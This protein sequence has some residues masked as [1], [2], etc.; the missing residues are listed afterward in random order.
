MNNNLQKLG[1]AN[2]YEFIEAIDSAINILQKERSK[3]RHI[4]G[5]KINSGLIELD[6]PKNLVIVGDLH[7]DLL[8]LQR[9]LEEIDYEH[10]LS[11]QNNKM[12]F[13]GDYV[14]RGTHSISVLY[15]ICYLK[16]KYPDSVILMRGNHEAHMEFPFSS[17]DLSLKIVEYFGDTYKKTIH[18]KISTLFQ[19]LY[20]V[21]IIQNKLLLVHGGLP[22]EIENKDFKKLIETV[23]SNSIHKKTLEEL[24]WN[25]PRIMQNGDNWEKSRRTYGRHFGTNITKEWLTMSKT[26]MIV[27]GHEPC[28]GFKIDHDD[29]VLT[30]FSCKET[31]PKF[32]AAY[33]FIS[34]IQLQIVENA[35]S[36]IKYIKKLR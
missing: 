17:H 20:L 31:Y 6:L 8:S 1:F 36:I 27:R 4:V 2:V 18:S 29:R 21:I 19:L 33:I 14:D 24:L 3:I 15:I 13:L 26:K 12:I 7:G 34:D 30:L 28:H 11:N 35:T 32:E 25:D 23:Q 16:Q 22:T 9:I 10:F 5:G